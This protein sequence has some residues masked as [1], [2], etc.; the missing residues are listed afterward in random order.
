M[1][2]IEAIL[3]WGKKL[4]ST[5]SLQK[6]SQEWEVDTQYQ[7][8]TRKNTVVS[9]W[10]LHGNYDAILWNLLY[11]WI[12]DALW[13]W[14][15]WDTKV[16]FHGDI[17]ADRYGDSM[18][19]S[20]YITKLQAQARIQNWDITIL[21]WNHEDIAFAIMTKQ[22]IYNNKKL[23]NISIKSF[24][25]GARNW[26]LEL[27]IY[28]D[29]I[30]NNTYATTLEILQWDN[31]WR[32]VLEFMCNMQ[33]IKI[34]DDT[35][36]VHVMPNPEM[37]QLIVRMGIDMINSLYQKW[38]KS[39]LLWIDTLT[40]TERAWFLKLRRLF[41]DTEHR[42]IVPDVIYR[43]IKKM[44]INVIVNGHDHSNAGKIQRI[45]W[46]ECTWVDFWYKK[47]EIPTPTSTLEFHTDWSMK[48]GDGTMHRCVG[49]ERNL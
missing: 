34:I 44:G 38:M 19:I 9:I 18:K 31:I 33:L 16:V 17:F 20:Q 10:D 41:L 48:Y 29:T 42:K 25:D 49:E 43:E 11:V 26:L 47:K 8:I 32:K 3:N 7:N 37:L 4:E 36:F 46:V 28:T 12:I 23:E 22:P 5:L 21:A 27:M 40:A 24:G 2:Q 35:L 30:S 14:I 13:N 6:N 45:F 1:P 15:W 39:Y